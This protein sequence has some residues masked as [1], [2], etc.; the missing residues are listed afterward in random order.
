MNIQIKGLEVH[1]NNG[2]HIPLF[3]CQVCKK[4]I[5]KTNNKC[6]AFSNSTEG[7]IAHAKCMG[8]VKNNK[9]VYP[10]SEH[11]EHFLF[12]LIHNIG[13]EPKQFPLEFE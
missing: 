4:T 8:E 9:T 1:E 11:L 7:V 6:L 2:S 10:K 5:D 13:V 12:N 3:V